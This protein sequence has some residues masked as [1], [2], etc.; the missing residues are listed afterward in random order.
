MSISQLLHG[1]LHAQIEMGFPQFLDF[2]LKRLHIFLTQF[3]GIHLNI[4]F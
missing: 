2:D 1:L 3:L 4:L